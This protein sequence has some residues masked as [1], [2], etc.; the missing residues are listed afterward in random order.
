MRKGSKSPKFQDVTGNRYGRLTVLAHAS[1]NERGE[2]RWLC[3]CDCGTE[4][5][6][7]GMSFKYG[8]TKS[9]GCLHKEVI[10]GMNNYQAKRAMKKHGD[11]IASSY[12]W[13]YRSGCL[14]RQAHKQKV[15]V[16]FESPAEFALYIRSIA[17]EKCPVFGETLTKGTKDMHIWSPSVDKIIPEKGYVRGNIQVISWFANAMKRDATPK[18]LVKFALWILKTVAKVEIKVEMEGEVICA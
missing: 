12:P 10:S 5:V 11:Y 9:C 7:L 15:P 17:P 3:R 4:K 2:H 16:G 8:G 14:I 6:Y 13:Y 18:Q 1:K